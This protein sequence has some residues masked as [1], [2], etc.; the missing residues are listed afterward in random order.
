MDN[1]G[2][3]ARGFQLADICLQLAKYIESSLLAVKINE[4][5]GLRKQILKRSGF[6]F[7]EKSFIL[8]P[9]RFVI[10]HNY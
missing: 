1:S 10:G 4:T 6:Y 2:I 7:T 8:D 9:D 5:F 3:K